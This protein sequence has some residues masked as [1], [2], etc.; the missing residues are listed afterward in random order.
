MGLPPKLK[1][2]LDRG[3]ILLIIVARV[4]PACQCKS[5]ENLRECRKEQVRAACEQPGQRYTT[6]APT[7]LTSKFPISGGATSDARDESSAPTKSLFSQATGKL[8]PGLCWS[9]AASWTRQ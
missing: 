2:C 1:E 4:L 6:P 7:A 8:G 3:I 9:F 5:K